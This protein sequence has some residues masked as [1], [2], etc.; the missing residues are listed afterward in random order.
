M[1]GVSNMEFNEI[2][3]TYALLD[4]LF[5]WN[6]SLL[7]TTTEDKKLL[8]NFIFRRHYT[9]YSWVA[10][11]MNNIE[12]AVSVINHYIPDHTAIEVAA[13]VG[14]LSYWLI[15]YGINIV[16][17]SD[18]YH[19]EW[20]KHMKFGQTAIQVSHMKATMAVYNNSN[21][22][23]VILS[24]PEYATDTGF[25]IYKAMCK[26]QWLLYIGEGCGGCTGDDKFNALVEK[27]LVTWIP[28]DTFD[29][30][31]DRLYLAKK[32]GE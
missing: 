20:A 9:Q 5:G 28:L 14:W 16:D 29:G 23:L 27:D 17:T 31:H 3:N 13:G 2:P 10:L 8:N 30:I 24:W 11:T 12:R 22:N 7:D 25:L 26:G 21:A 1:K 19:D 4:R 32:G 6:P 15:Q 18:C